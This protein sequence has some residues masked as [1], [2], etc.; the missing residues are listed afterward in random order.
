MAIALLLLIYLTFVGLG[1]PDTVLGSSFP[2]ISEALSL[3]GDYAGYIGMVVSLFTRKPDR[4][5]VDRAFSCYGQ[6]VVVE[7]RQALGD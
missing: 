7:Q 2:A 6:K 5:L 4:H 1:L 3:P